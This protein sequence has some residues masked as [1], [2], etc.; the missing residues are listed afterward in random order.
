MYNDG[1]L[2]QRILSNIQS[3]LLFHQVVAYG[4]FTC[5][6][7]EGENI[8]INI[9]ITIP[10]RQCPGKISELPLTFFQE[11]TKMIYFDL[12]SDAEY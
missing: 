4:Y 3:I 1:P 12:K 6:D 5:I 11:A 10:Y 9:F 7:F 2:G 8:P